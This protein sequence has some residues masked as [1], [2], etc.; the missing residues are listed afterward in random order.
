MRFGRKTHMRI[1][2][3]IYVYIK[4]LRFV[5]RNL[6]VEVFRLSR[7]NYCGDTYEAN[8]ILK[9]ILVS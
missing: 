4:F 2:I 3:Y 6:E 1:C 5:V 7:K 8:N 9:L